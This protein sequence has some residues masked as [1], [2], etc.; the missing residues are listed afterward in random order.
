M[1][2]YGKIDIENSKL[3]RG[4]VS[5]RYNFLNHLGI[6]AEY[7]HSEPR[8]AYNS[9][10]SVFD[11]QSTDEIGGGLDYLIF[12]KY[13]IFARY[14]YVKYTDDNSS[15]LT[16]GV[17][18]SLGSITYSRNFG[19]VGTMDILD[20]QITYPLYQRRFIGS[21]G[22]EF[23][24]YKY[25]NADLQNASALIAGATWRPNNIIS[26]DLQGQMLMNEIYKDDFRLYFKFNYWFLSKLGII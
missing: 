26:L 13:N 19:Y 10:F 3:Y 24:S 23:S 7:L 12:N 4:E 21:A 6:S 8:V 17:N 25:Q 11:S 2:A 14:Y 15:R 5:L 9:I 1:S 22:F 20:A 16:F 18:S